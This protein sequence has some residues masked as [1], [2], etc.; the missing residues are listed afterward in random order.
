VVTRAL[1]AAGVTFEVESIE[2][3]D[4]PTGPDAAVAPAVEGGTAAEAPSRRPAPEPAP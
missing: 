3:I 1:R 2:R 4:A